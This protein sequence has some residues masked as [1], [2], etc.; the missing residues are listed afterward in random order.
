MILISL[1][2]LFSATYVNESLREMNRIYVDCVDVFSNNYAD[3]ECGNW[4]I[5]VNYMNKVVLYGYLLGLGI[6]LVLFGFKPL[7]NF[8]APEKEKKKLQLH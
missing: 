1:T 4:R 3:K 8:I 7:F 2:L 5:Y 6:P